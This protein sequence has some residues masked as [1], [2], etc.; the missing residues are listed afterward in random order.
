MVEAAQ[1]SQEIWD[2]LP[3]L[4]QLCVM[5][6]LFINFCTYAL[7]LLPLRLLDSEVVSS[8]KVGQRINQ[9]VVCWPRER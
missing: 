6:N 5:L 8:Q 1:K 2:L 9:I 4:S 3:A 7:P